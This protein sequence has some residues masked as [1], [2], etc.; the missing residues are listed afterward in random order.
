MTL[1]G[2]NRGDG[3]QSHNQKQDSEWES[4]CRDLAETLVGPRDTELKEWDG[5]GGRGLSHRIIH[6]PRA[7]WCREP[8]WFCK[9]WVGW[10]EKSRE[11][12]ARLFIHKARPGRHRRNPKL[13]QPLR[14]RGTWGRGDML[15]RQWGAP[16]RRVIWTD[17]T[18]PGGG[19]F[20][21]NTT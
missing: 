4:R 9:L 18:R 3:A 11:E 15:P 7:S 12:S 13:L 2:S 16:T 21:V 20:W 19:A 6:S 5:G 1:T 10:G 17:T 14:V 8:L